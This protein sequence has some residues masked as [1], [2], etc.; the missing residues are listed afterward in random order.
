[1]PATMPSRTDI[2]PR[3]GSATRPGRGTAA[4]KAHPHPFGSKST[5]IGLWGCGFLRGGPGRSLIRG[6]AQPNVGVPRVSEIVLFGPG[7]VRLISGV[8]SRQCENRGMV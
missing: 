7:I 1:M 6:D 8:A 4:G 2:Q 5:E 3:G